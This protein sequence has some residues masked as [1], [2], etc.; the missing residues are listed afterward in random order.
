[1]QNPSTPLVKTRQGTLSGITEQGIHLWRGIP[2]AAPPVGELRWRAPQ[3]PAR[4]QG[5]R[6]P[7]P[8]PPPA[9][10]ILSTAASWAAAIPVASQKIVSTLTSGHPPDALSR[11]GHGLAARRRVYHWRRQP[12][13]YDGKAL[14]ARDVVVVT[15]NYR[16]GHLGFFAHPAL[17]GEDGERV[18][19]FALLDQIAALQ[20]VQ[21]N[22]HAFGGDATNVTLFGESAGAQRA[23]ANG[24]AEIPRTVP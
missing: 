21:D 2:F 8:S 11:A 6:R 7:T 14:A 13:P 10:K 24:I 19:N 16:L 23:L 18:Y 5:V 17:E 4:W 12:A 1:M 9:G 20:W 15:V 22:I 3:P